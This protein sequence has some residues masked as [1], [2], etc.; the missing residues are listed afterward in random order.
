MFTTVIGSVR[1]GSKKE[2]W[3][4]DVACQTDT[5][6]HSGSSVSV[7]PVENRTTHNGHMAGFAVAPDFGHRGVEETVGGKEMKLLL[8]H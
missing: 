1:I 7:E 8:T 5:I 2:G 4:P 6:F 3:K